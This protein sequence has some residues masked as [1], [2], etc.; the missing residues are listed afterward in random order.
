VVSH[1]FEQSG[2]LLDVSGGKRLEEHL[3]DD[4]DVAREHLREPL[5]AGCR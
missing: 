1:R 5:A 2:E 3:A 4:L